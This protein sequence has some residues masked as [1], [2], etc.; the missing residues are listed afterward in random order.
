M[1]TLAKTCLILMLVSFIKTDGLSELYFLEGT[2]K[3]ENKEVYETW[4]QL[5]D[6]TLEGQGYKIKDGAKVVTER[7]RIRIVK[8]K[9]TYEATVPDQNNN[10]TIAF[11]LNKATAGVF[12]F[13]NPAHDFPKKIQYRP[14][15]GRTIQVRVLGDGDKGFEYKILKQ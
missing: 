6:G 3:T 4:K 7:L 5:P 2:W 15:D 1:K 10:Q 11:E 12:S 8:G 13:E 14:V 9:T